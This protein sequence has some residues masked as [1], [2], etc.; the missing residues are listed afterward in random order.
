MTQYSDVLGYYCFRGPCSVHLLGE[1][2]GAGKGG[3][4]IGKEYSLHSVI[5]QEIMS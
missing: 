3:M 5:T 4:E 1:V 2:N